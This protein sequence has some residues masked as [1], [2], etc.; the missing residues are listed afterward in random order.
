[1][2]LGSL[3]GVPQAGFEAARVV[4]VAVA[5][6]AD[7]ERAVGVRVGF[8]DVV[9][10]GVAVS[11]PAVARRRKAIYAA[12]LTLGRV[13]PLRVARLAAAV[14]T[15]FD[16]LVARLRTGAAVSVAAQQIAA[17]KARPRFSVQRAAASRLS[18]V[19]ASLLLLSVAHVEVVVA[20]VGAPI[21]IPT[22]LRPTAL[23]V[24]LAAVVRASEADAVLAPQNVAPPSV[25]QIPPTQGAAPAPSA[26]LIAPAQPR[27]A[28]SPT[29]F[30]NAVGFRVALAALAL[31]LAQVLVGAPARLTR[32]SP[33]L[34]A[35][36]QTVKPK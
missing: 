1:M 28:P 12:R 11:K 4:V 15:P 3:V 22:P 30:S 23:V 13:E 31:F 24:R 9:L 21:V 16:T 34:R 26:P 2:A 33:L 5:G 17:E 25:G 8:V 29:E 20:E 6:R 14:P 7:V 19:G 10:V 32:S 36:R 27:P 18:E 35:V